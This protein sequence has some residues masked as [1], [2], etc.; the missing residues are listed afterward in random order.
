MDG[1]VSYGLVKKSYF[2]PLMIFALTCIRFLGETTPC[3][4]ATI[5]RLLWSSL[6]SK[7]H[8]FLSPVPLPQAS[9]FL[10]NMESPFVPNSFTGKRKSPVGNSAIVQPHVGS[11]AVHEYQFLPEQPSDTYE[12]ASPH[13]YDTPVEASNSRIPS[14]TSGSQLLHGSEEA[15]PSYAF[16]GHTSGSSLLPPSSR[17]QVFPAAPT[18]YEMTQSNSNLSSVPVEGQFDTS[19]VA[20]FE[21]PPVSSERRAYHDEDTSRVERKRKV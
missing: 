4:I 14:L 17:P 12:R 21:D 20:A 15:A 6:F 8:L 10:P 5:L 2:V 19:Q 13:Y 7:Y 16:Q 3:A 18:D 1:Y 11:R 9:A